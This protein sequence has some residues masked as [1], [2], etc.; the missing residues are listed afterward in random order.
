MMNRDYRQEEIHPVELSVCDH[1][2]DEVYYSEITPE[3]NFM[4]LE[5]V[6]IDFC[7]CGE[8]RKECSVCGRSLFDI[9]RDYLINKLEN[10]I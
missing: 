5:C 10:A 2:N 4:C 7:D 1:C 3:S 6:K 9:F 8:V